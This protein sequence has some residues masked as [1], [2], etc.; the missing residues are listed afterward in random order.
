MGKKTFVVLLLH[1]TIMAI[2]PPPV[3]SGETIRVATEN[4][5]PYVASN[6]KHYGVLGQIVTEAFKLEGINVEFNFFTGKRAYKLAKTGEYDATMPWARRE[7]RLKL[8]YYGEPVIESDHEVFFFRRGKKFKWDPKRQNYEDIRGFDI[9]A[10]IGYNYGPKFMEAEKKKIV[11]VSRMLEISQLFQMLLSGRLDLMI[12][13]ERI[14]LYELKTTID[15]EK[16]MA[17]QSIVAIDEP[18]EYDYLLISKKSK[19]GAHFFEAMNRGLRKLKESGRHNEIVNQ[20][21]K[22]F[23]PTSEISK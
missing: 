23:M 8:F 5:P 13:P 17:I 15:K 16:A 18:I 21:M 7:E 2:F 14:A 4:Y 20:F 10:I 9:G 19:K 22:E 1:F 6:L 12:S 11:S 3:L